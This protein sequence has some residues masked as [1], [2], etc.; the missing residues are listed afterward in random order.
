M[1]RGTFGW[2]AELRQAQIKYRDRK[3]KPLASLFPH[4]IHKD[5]LI[6][7]PSLPSPFTVV[8]HRRHIMY[9]T[10]SYATRAAL[11]RPAPSDD[12]SDGK[13]EEDEIDGV[14]LTPQRPRVFF[15]LVPR[16]PCSHSPFLR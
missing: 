8:V 12:E 15:R 4:T 7:L 1:S 16:L 11:K 13:H 9:N 5:T 10:R 6:R 3:V 2:L 14:S